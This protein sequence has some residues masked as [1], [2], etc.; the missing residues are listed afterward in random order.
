ME[1]PDYR[2]RGEAGTRAGDARLEPV[3]RLLQRLLD[4]EIL[5]PE[6]VEPLLAGA[7]AAVRSRIQGD[8]EAARPHLERLAREGEALVRA[9]LLDAADGCAL[10][11]AI[12]Q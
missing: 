12:R 9:G 3:V 10:A 6:E 1:P 5:L 8:E 11:Q 4:A 7:E 2:P